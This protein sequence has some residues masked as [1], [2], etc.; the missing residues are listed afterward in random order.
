MIKNRLTVLLSGNAFF[1]CTKHIREPWLGTFSQKVDFGKRGKVRVGRAIKEITKHKKT[2]QK[3][4]TR[5]GHTPLERF[6]V[7][8]FFSNALAVDSEWLVDP[9]R[10]GPRLEPVAIARWLRVGTSFEEFLIN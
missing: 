5:N 2:H 9:Y 10:T 1:G 8:A 6:S 7:P 3:R 4:C